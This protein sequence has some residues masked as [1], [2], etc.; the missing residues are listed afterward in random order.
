M[1]FTVGTGT[2]TNGSA[3]V[4]NVSLS[5]GTLAYFAS[6]TRMVVG[7]NPVVREIEA[8][9][10]PTVT[11]ITLRSPWQGTGGTYDFLANQTSEGLRD[12]VQSIRS[13]NATI[14]SFIDSI[15]VQNTGDSVVQRTA[16]GRV[17]TSNATESNDAVALGQTGTAYNKNVQT[18]ATD[19]TAGRV[20]TVGA[21]GLLENTTQVDGDT[22]NNQTQ[23]VRITVDGIS[24]VLAG[25][26]IGSTSGTRASQV[27][28]QDA[29]GSNTN[30][31]M[32]FRHARDGAFGPTARVLS[33]VNL[34]DPARLDEA[35]TFTGIKTFN[36]TAIDNGTLFSRATAAGSVVR[37][38]NTLGMLGGIGF[39]SDG[40]LLVRN[41]AI[42]GTANTFFSVRPNGNALVFGD[43]QVDGT[44]N[45]SSD[46]R[47]KSN[48]VLVSDD[49]KALAAWGKVR[50]KFFQW[51]H[52]IESKGEDQAR[53]HAGWMAQEIEQAFLDEGLSFDHYA[54]LAKTPVYE[55]VETGETEE[56]EEFI[57]KTITEEKQEIQV[58]DGIP[59]LV[60]V[61]EDRE[62]ECCDKVQVVD[63]EGNPIEGMFHD[64]PRTRIVSKPITEQ[65]IVDYTYH[66]RYSQC[67]I[68]E[69][70]YLRKQI[71]Q[72]SALNADPLP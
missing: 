31:E 3:T 54:L 69:T 36:A 28:V 1:A 58:I 57:T 4:T 49:D 37:F 51:N 48:A 62:V 8:I 25:V 33:N 40:S 19:A 43:L 15:D 68:M 34:P 71:E 61:T 56:V 17:K 20:L 42:A 26:N 23:F 14:Q 30:P 45:E 12:A 66:L 70:A 39:D 24:G 64:V 50:A 67:L 55:D 59:T 10:A 32:Y 35:Q 72:L 7:V 41:S 16:N 2:F 29:G 52:A 46:E 21:G 38:G 6:G 47:L 11:T 13:S 5:S 22:V 9:A 63:E 65:V 18:S 53:H 44:I 27:L 60:A